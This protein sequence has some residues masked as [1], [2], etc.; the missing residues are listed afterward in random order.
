MRRP[1]DRRG[2]AAKDAPAAVLAHPDVGQQHALVDR[3]A[4]V[5]HLP[6]RIDRGDDDI[7]E[8]DAIGDAH[9]ERGDVHPPQRRDPLFEVDRDRSGRADPDQLV[10]R[11][12][13]PAQR[14]LVLGEQRVAPSA[15]SVVD[16][17][18]GRINDHGSAR[19]ISRAATGLPSCRPTELATERPADWITL[20][21]IDRLGRFARGARAR[22]RAAALRRAGRSSSRR[23]WVSSRSAASLARAASLAAAASSLACCGR[24]FLGFGC[25]LGRGGGGGGL[26]GLGLRGF[27]RR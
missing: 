4:E 15:S 17:D 20:S 26:V 27:P 14:V 7:V 16:I 24:R 2:V 25:R 18:A 22:P 13:Q 1:R 6:L 11:V 19:R 23:R 5:A 10:P 8:R 9:L 21:V 3:L 12:D